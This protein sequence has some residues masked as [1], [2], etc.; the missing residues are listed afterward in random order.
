MSRHPSLDRLTA[1]V[2][3]ASAA[4][5][6]KEHR[7]T[8]P[9]RPPAAGGVSALA[10]ILV[11]FPALAFASHEPNRVSH[12]RTKYPALH[13]LINDGARQSAAF[14]AL[15]TRLEASDVVVYLECSHLT[16]GRGG[17]LGF[18]GLASGTRYLKV[19]LACTLRPATVTWLIGHELQHAVE[20]ADAPEVVD[21]DGLRALY[22]RIGV[23]VLGDG[24][25][26]DTQQ[27]INAGLLIR[28]QLSRAL[29]DVELEESD[30]RK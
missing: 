6:R 22:R 14:Q 23:D 8:E 20:I 1:V 7:T 17:E 4:P 12:I 28:E 19:G 24:Q 30:N 18:L 2:R 9:H 10:L 16:P 3:P 25:R 26:F 27:A 5:C 29:N 11:L 13:T 15:V 21:V